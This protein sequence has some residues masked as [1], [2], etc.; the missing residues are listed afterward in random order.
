MKDINCA[1]SV[2]SVF[3]ISWFSFFYVYKLVIY[4]SATFPC[5]N[6]FIR[7]ELPKI[8]TI[9]WTWIST[10][11][12]NWIIWTFL[13]LCFHCV[14]PIGWATGGLV[15]LWQTN[16]EQHDPYT[17]LSC[18][19][20]TLVPFWSWQ[21]AQLSACIPSFRFPWLIEPPPTHSHSIGLFACPGEEAVPSR[22]SLPPV[23]TFLF[24]T[25]CL[26]SSEGTDIGASIIFSWLLCQAQFLLACVRG[27]V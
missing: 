15:S 10:H 16:L 22:K 12:F 27:G 19:A 3:K 21:V 6:Y 5:P 7:T 26:S 14:L 13:W 4:L 17:V 23:L 9:Q 8:W 11:K 18:L 24:P 20:I 2:M 1:P 25:K